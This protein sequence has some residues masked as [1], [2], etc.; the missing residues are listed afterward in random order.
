MSALWR[1]RVLAVSSE[2]VEL[3]VHAIHPDAG[4]FSA[5]KVFAQ[6]LLA[7]A[8][9]L[10]DQLPQDGDVEGAVE[11]VHISETRNYPF[12]TVA[13]KVRVASRVRSSGLT[14]EDGDAWLAAF[15][16]AWNELWDDTEQ[17]P[18][19]RLTVRLSDPSLLTGLA[20][21]MEWE[22]AAYD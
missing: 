13:A 12:D 15:G 8:P 6:R 20:S 17:T 5:S 18:T 9:G 3:R 16:R 22:T 10:R 7:D 14:P 4:S 11:T 1:A 2:T 19:A 21:G